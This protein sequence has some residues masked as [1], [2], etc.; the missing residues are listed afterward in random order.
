VDRRELFT[1]KVPPDSVAAILSSRSRRGR[2]RRPPAGY[3]KDLRAICDRYGILLV[4]DEVQ[5]GVGRTGKMWACEYEGSSLIFCFPRRAGQRNA[6]RRD[7]RQRIHHE[8]EARRA[9]HHV[10]GNPV[11]C[12]AALAT[13]DIVEK[14]L[15]PN[16]AKMGDRLITARA[17]SRKVRGDRRRARRGLMVG[18]E[19]VKDRETRSPRRHPHEIVGRAF[20]KGL[21]LL[22]CGKSSLRLAP[23][24]SWM[25]MTSTPPSG[26]ST[27][28][29]TRCRTSVKI[30]SMQDA[31]ARYVRDGDVVVIEGLR[32]SSRRRGHEIIR[33]HRRDLT[34]C[35]L[36]PD[37]IY[38]QMIAAG[39]AKKLVFSWAGNPGVGSL[40]AFRRAVKG[41]RSRS[42]NIRILG[43]SKVSAG[44][45]RLPFGRCATTRAPICRAPIR[46]SSR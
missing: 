40:H 36:T 4:C 38:D 19:F 15:L 7:H 5:C 33:Q 39:C 34:L 18:V 23:R 14:E 20:K 27:S 3:L 25:S 16:V 9:R 43:C 35:R 1:K 21:L 41:S 45:A 12:A 37:L 44:A 28:A 8:M 2:L 17:S 26:S 13:L 42:R 6:D 31:V 10:C 24:W 46:A 32:T 22:G 30:V 29:C 11:C